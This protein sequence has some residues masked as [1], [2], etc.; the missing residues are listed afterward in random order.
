MICKVKTNISIFKNKFWEKFE[1]FPNHCTPLCKRNC[2]TFYWFLYQGL[3]YLPNKNG[4]KVLSLQPVT[5]GSEYQATNSFTILCITASVDSS[6]WI[7][8]FYCPPLEWLYLDSSTQR[9][10]H[11]LKHICLYE[12]V[13]IRFATRLPAQLV[14]KAARQ[15]TSFSNFQKYDLDY[16]KV[17]YLLN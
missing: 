5:C 17:F 10:Y 9:L 8:L 13:F 12:R 11:Y 1:M 3:C 7:C 15:L 14:R 4:T 16:N 2:F 6:T